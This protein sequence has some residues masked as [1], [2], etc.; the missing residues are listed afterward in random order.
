[1]Q[2][3]YEGLDSPKYAVVD[4]A[5]SSMNGAYETQIQLPTSIYDKPNSLP[6]T[7]II[8][9]ETEKQIYDEPFEVNEDYG[10]I[11]HEPPSNV[12]KIYEQF[13][14]KKIHKINHHE[15]RFVVYTM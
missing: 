4:T 9:L 7:M 15:V 13:E 14:G 8:T 5:L 3:D 6:S 10:P 2:P 1:M 11:Y 12:N